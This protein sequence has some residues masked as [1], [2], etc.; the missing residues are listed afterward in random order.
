MIGRAARF[1]AIMRELNVEE[2]ERDLQRPLSVRLTGTEPAL[3]DQVEGLLFRGGEGE[4]RRTLLPDENP[5]GSADLELMVVSA[6]RPAAQAEI[7]AAHR[8]LARGA[9]AL[10]VVVGDGRSGPPDGL[11]EFPREHIVEADLAREAEARDV[12]ARTIADAAPGLRLALARRFPSLRT[13]VAEQL[14][15]ETSAANAQF[16]LVSSVPA[17]IP[18]LGGLIGG[19]AD[20][21][22]LTKNQA[23]L[24]LKLAGI[25]GRDLSDRVRLLAEI[26]PVVGGAFAWRSLARML[27]GLLPSY[28]SAVPKTAIAYVGT[29]TVGAIASSYFTFG[30]RPPPAVARRLAQRG[31][32]LFR[33]V[34]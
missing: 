6:G 15:R 31:A 33:R 23:L 25:H 4:V 13:G 5:P 26:A 8:L 19:A 28:A 32:E 3:L 11:P 34:V 20:M 27:A 30:R 9:P 10:L 16:A 18:L 7:A 24:L 12:L 21:V 22:V 14:I 1:W 29:Y 2:L 17:A